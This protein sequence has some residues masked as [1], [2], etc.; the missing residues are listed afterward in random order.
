[1]SALTL[2]G[3]LALSAL[4]RHTAA[5][6]CPAGSMLWNP[7]SGPYAHKQKCCPISVDMAGEWTCEQGA[8]SDYYQCLTC[9][10][11]ASGPFTIKPGENYDVLQLRINGKAKADG[12]MWTYYFVYDSG[13]EK[14]IQM[15]VDAPSGTVLNATCA[16][17]YPA[18]TTFPY[19]GVDCRFA[20][21]SEDR[22]YASDYQW[23]WYTNGVTQAPRPDYPASIAFDIYVEDQYCFDVPAAPAP[24]ATSTVTVT[25]FGSTQTVLETLYVSTVYTPSGTVT[26]TPISTITHTPEMSTVTETETSE[27]DLGPEYYTDFVNGGLTTPLTATIQT[28]NDVTTTPQT[29][30][31]TATVTPD[32]STAYETIWAT[33]T[34]PTKTVTAVQTVAAGHADCTEY[35]LVFPSA[36]CPSNYVKLRPLQRRALD[37]AKRDAVTVTVDGGAATV[38]STV[39]ATATPGLGEATVTGEATTETEEAATPRTTVTTTETVTLPQLQIPI[40]ST[41]YDE[42]E[43]PYV[44][45]TST[46]YHEAPTPTSTAFSTAST[47]LTTVTQTSTTTLPQETATVTNTAYVQATTCAAKTVYTQPACAASDLLKTVVQDA[48]VAALNLYKALGGKRVIVDCGSAG[49]FSY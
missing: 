36:C 41:F 48:Q 8:E 4:A 13:R 15:L 27:V 6:S 12:T 25:T 34:P 2:L 3:L 38:T 7:T 5:Q 23:D 14:D 11:S 49:T 9:T 30:T 37:L 40:Y 20:Q 31:V 32:A 45:L 10:T 29:A 24:P 33:S 19:D 28:S 39:S 21:A 42:A 35:R 22:Y 16:G 26:I 43:T 18:G 47:P 17:A 46:V 1:M 44:T